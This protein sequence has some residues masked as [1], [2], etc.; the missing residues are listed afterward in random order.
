MVVIAMAT[1]L[2][3]HAGATAEDA[4]TKDTTDTEGDWLEYEVTQISYDIQIGALVAV[5]TDADSAY[6]L[7]EIMDG[8]SD[9]RVAW[10]LCAASGTNNREK[11]TVIASGNGNL[12][13][14][15]VS[16]QNRQKAT[17]TATL[18][19]FGEFTVS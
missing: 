8:I 11:G 2:T 15:Q 17:Y 10:Q 19:G 6:L 3:F 18:T 1:D 9:S 14:V 7:D 5:G 13:N 12:T 4:T 16:A